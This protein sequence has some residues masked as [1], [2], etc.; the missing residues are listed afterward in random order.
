[1]EFPATIKPEFDFDEA[2]CMTELSRRAYRVFE[3]D[4][5][6]VSWGAFL[7]DVD[8]FEADFFGISPREAI[9]MDPQQRLMLELAWQ[10]LEDAGFLTTDLAEQQG[11]VF[12][13]A[14]W[15][16]YARLWGSEA[17]TLYP[18]SKGDA[19]QGHCLWLSD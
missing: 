1:M 9:Q 19:V 3:S 5:K 13:G 7:N 11:G 16:D 4:D 17:E 10:A 12:I 8:R 15:Q 14:L 2:I 6:Q 18:N